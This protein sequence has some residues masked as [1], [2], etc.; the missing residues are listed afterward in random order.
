MPLPIYGGSLI[1]AARAV[2]CTF[3]TV[4]NIATERNRQFWTYIYSFQQNQRTWQTDRH[5]GTA[6]R[7]RLRLHSIARQ[8]LTLANCYRRASLRYLLT[9]LIILFL[10]SHFDFLFIPSFSCGRLSWLPVSFLLHIKY[11]LSYRIVSYRTGSETTDQIQNVRG[12]IYGTDLLY[13]HAN[14]VGNP[15]YGGE[16][17]FPTIFGILRRAPAVNEKVWCFFLLFYLCV[18]LSNYEVS[19][20]GNAI[21]HLV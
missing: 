16:S 20:N 9:I 7:H 6:W 8:K 18:T 11:T 4:I 17:L 15:R 21:K 19:G 14:M 13:H 5:T 12:C 3:V 10:V 1:T 2:S